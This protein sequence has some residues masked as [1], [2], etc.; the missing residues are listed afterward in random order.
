MGDYSLP[1][2]R[3]ASVRIPTL[4]I[5]GEKSIPVLRQ[6][7]QQL[8]EVLPKTHHRTLERQS[9]NVS[10]KASPRCCRSSSPVETA[11]GRGLLP[12]H[13]RLIENAAKQ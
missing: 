5:G 12:E 9:H 1:T 10:A 6:A 7:A 11:S 8:A 2:Q 3:A 13:E 4:V